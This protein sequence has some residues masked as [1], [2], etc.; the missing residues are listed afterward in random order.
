MSRCL[1]STVDHPKS[2]SVHDPPH[3]SFLSQ[4]SEFLFTPSLTPFLHWLIVL[5]S[6]HCARIW[7]RPPTAHKETIPALMECPCSWEGQVGSVLW[8]N[9]IITVQIRVQ[10]EA[11]RQG[12]ESRR[13]SP[14]G[15]WGQADPSE[16]VSFGQRLEEEGEPACAHAEDTCYEADPRGL[17][18]SGWGRRTGQAQGPNSKSVLL[19]PRLAPLPRPLVR[20]AF[21]RL[22][23]FST[24]TDLHSYN[25]GKTD[26]VLSLWLIIYGGFEPKPR[27]QDQRH[28]D[29]MKGETE[30][31]GGSLRAT[32]SNP[33]IHFPW[34]VIKHCSVFS[35]H[36][37]QEEEGACKVRK[38]QHYAV[39][40]ESS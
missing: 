29:L 31:V 16:H 39:H 23:S 6:G 32:L 10:G 30:G 20:E 5:C 9:K 38:G 14:S 35:P 28:R 8:S 33:S 1:I 26:V 24:D 19:P 2:L 7:G 12:T 17:P 22:Q 34:A 21:W 15:S 37:E 18:S 3:P 40:L 25:L 13:G 4:K 27:A 11:S 36:G